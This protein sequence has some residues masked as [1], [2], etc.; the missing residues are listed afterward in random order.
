VGVKGD[1]APRRNAGGQ[2]VSDP[3]RHDLGLAGASGGDD[4][5]VAAPVLDGRESVAIQQ[6]QR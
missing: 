2:Q 4:L 6:G 3:L 1:D 5:H